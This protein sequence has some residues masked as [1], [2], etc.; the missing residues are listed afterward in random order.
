MNK[1]TAINTCSSNE[2]TFSDACHTATEHPYQTLNRQS[3]HHRLRT[4]SRLG[5]RHRHHL[6][7]VVVRHTR[8]SNPDGN[9][10]VPMA[11]TNSLGDFSQ[12]LVGACLLGAGGFLLS[13]QVLIRSELVSASR[14]GW[15]GGFT[16]FFGNAGMGLLMIPLGIG[17]CML[18]A[19]TYRRWANLLIWAAL[20]AS[21]AG[22]LNSVRIEFRPTT[23]WQLMTYIVMIASGGGLMFRGARAYDAEGEPLNNTLFESERDELRREI[24]E[25]KSKIYKRDK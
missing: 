13:N 8:S 2:A 18:F 14:G 6:N 19:G 17:V 23:L 20:A 21:L 10:S 9:N 5:I 12:F 22:I 25:L 11:R 1:S 15:S 7:E 16:L 3:P 4:S 24:E